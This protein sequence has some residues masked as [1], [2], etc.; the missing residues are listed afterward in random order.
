[1]LTL[2]AVSTLNNSTLPR[3]APKNVS[4]KGPSSEPAVNATFRP[5]RSLGVRHPE[6]AGTRTP[7][8]LLRTKPAIEMTG[9]PLPRAMAGA[10]RF[11]W[12]TS[13]CPAPTSWIVTTDPVPSSIV[14]SRPA[15][16]NHPFCSARKNGACEPFGI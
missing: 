5:S 15:L 7:M 9:N 12:P 2:A 1:V 14:T 16:R 6:P 4:M 3:E 11:A 13:N 8:S 10:E